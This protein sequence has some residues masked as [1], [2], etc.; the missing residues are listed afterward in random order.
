MAPSRRAALLASHGEP[1]LAWDALRSGGPARTD[2]DA[3]LAVR[4]LTEL[5]RYAQA[6]SLLAREAAP[7]S[8]R[9]ATRY[10]L[11]RARLSF[12]AG[13]AERALELLDA[14]PAPAGDPLSAYHEFV[15]AQSLAKKGD[16][17]AAA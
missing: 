4:L 14:A 8:D 11:Q 6:E 5:G 16:G 15:R 9:A 2:A 10:Y 13:R 12:D 3:V 17:A 7:K 1:R